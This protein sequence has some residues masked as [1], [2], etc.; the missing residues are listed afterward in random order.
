MYICVQGAGARVL[1]PAHQ[2]DDRVGRPG[3][4]HAHQADRRGRGG[5]GA[6]DQALQAPQ[7]TASSGL[8]L[9]ILI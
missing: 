6:R 9:V 3:G 1:D 5:Q 4:G 2:G 7:G 8:S